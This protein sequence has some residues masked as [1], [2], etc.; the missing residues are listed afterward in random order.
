[1]HIGTRR[2]ERTEHKIIV[3]WEH[4]YMQVKIKDFALYHGD[5]LCSWNYNFVHNRNYHHRKTTRSSVLNA[6]RAK[7][8][9][10]QNTYHGVSCA[11]MLI[12][13]IRY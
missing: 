10:V 12:P 7:E 1:M 13:S 2:T 6:R 4:T 8:L 11:S 3:E 5:F 9:V